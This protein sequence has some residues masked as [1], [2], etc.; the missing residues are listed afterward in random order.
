MACR[1]RDFFVE[2]NETAVDD[3]W[4]LIRLW[5]MLAR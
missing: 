5:V 2:L 1:D 4:E 3:G